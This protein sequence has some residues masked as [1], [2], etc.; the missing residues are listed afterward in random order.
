MFCFVSGET[1]YDKSG[2]PIIPDEK[3]IVVL[4]VDQKKR[5]FVKDKLINYL[6]RN[7]AAIRPPQIK[8]QQQAADKKEILGRGKYDRNKMTDKPRKKY[9]MTVKYVRTKH[10]PRTGIKISAEKNGIIYGPCI[11]ITALT[12]LIAVSKAQISKVMRGKAEN[13]T[14][15]KFIKG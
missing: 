14:G 8:K 11:S 3:G 12:K 6:L 1:I 15:F 10:T 2:S 9:V 13:K 7:G 4:E 5:R